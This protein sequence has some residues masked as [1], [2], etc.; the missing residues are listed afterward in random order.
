MTTERTIFQICFGLII[1]GAL[2]W[3][4][5]ALAPSNDIILS[6]FPNSQMIRSVFYAIIGIA[7]IVGCYYWFSY[8]NEV[9]LV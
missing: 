8:P 6:I 5:V 2:N 9:C 3:F 1:I 7:G 4:L